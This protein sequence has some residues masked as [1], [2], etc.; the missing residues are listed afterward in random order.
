MLKIIYR[1]KN[2]TLFNKCEYDDIEF[3][4]NI[5]IYIYRFF[6]NLMGLWD[7][8]S[9]SVLSLSGSGVV[10]ENFITVFCL[11]DIQCCTES[12]QLLYGCLIQFGI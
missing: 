5:Y 12:D 10:T 7:M 1:L 9:L 8:N 3:P 4:Y 11:N 6:L 2:Y